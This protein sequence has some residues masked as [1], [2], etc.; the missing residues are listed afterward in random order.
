MKVGILTYHRA[1]NY[2][3]LLQA[4]A[5]KTYLSSLGHDVSFID[6]WPQYHSDYFKLFSWNT[7]RQRGMKGKQAMLKSCCWIVPRWIRKKRLQDFMYQQLHLSKCPQYTNKEGIT[8]KY[9]VVVYGSDQIWRKQHLSGVGF[10]DWYFGCDNVR[11]DKKV[12]YAGSMGTIV[13]NSVNDSYVQK[14]MRN[15]NYISVR[16]IDLQDYLT[17]LDVSSSHV[18]DPVFLLS[19][20][21][22]KQIE[23][24]KSRKGKYILFYN[25]L[26]TSESTKFTEQLS[27]K[28][29]LPIVEI[30][31]K[32]SLSHLG[33]R[34]VS[35][36]SVERFLRLID[37]AEYVVSNSFHGVAFSIIYEKQFFST[38]M[39]SKRN[40][41]VSLLRS[42]G[43]SER[44]IEDSVVPSAIHPIDYSH[45]N[46]SLKSLT[47]YSKSF[48]QKAIL[49]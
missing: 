4:Y 47:N 33:S 5:T 11:A 43:L 46:N 13:S 42:A 12:V 29:Q 2:G 34:Y 37:D 1:E 3:A 48:I 21:Q 19:R 36:A 40:R 27:R 28:M 24:K 38:G 18:I 49:P 45:V 25:L 7:F 6:Y 14:A 31:K 23:D 16:E 44:Y 30:N 35:T 41:V 39:R 10:D 8:E 20:E 26:N 9:D 22:W 15:F 17:K 32:L